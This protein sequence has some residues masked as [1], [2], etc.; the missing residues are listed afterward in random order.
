MRGDGLHAS[1]EVISEQRGQ[2][3]E[4]EVEERRLPALLQLARLRSS[5]ICLDHRPPE[6]PDMIGADAGAVGVPEE[7]AVL[8]EL[9]RALER[10]E[11]LVRE[12]ER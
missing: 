10:Q 4:C 8:L 2:L 5:E 1:S 3:A 6:W 11:Q 7:A 12:A 9:F